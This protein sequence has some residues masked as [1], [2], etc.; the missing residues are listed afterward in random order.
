PLNASPQAPPML[1]YACVYLEGHRRS[2]GRRRVLL[3]LDQAVD[4]GLVEQDA[5][6]DPHARELALPLEL[7]DG[8][9]THAE[10]GGRVG[11]REEPPGSC[12]RGRP[13]PELTCS[14]TRTTA[15]QALGV[16]WW[17][18]S[19]HSRWARRHYRPAHCTARSP[20]PGRA[21]SSEV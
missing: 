1:E 21:A 16:F 13:A 14:L 2:R 4:V 11:D 9:G 6:A 7:P 17:N 8:P 5:A 19:G 12:R 18:E 10:V 20:Q 3:P 15:S